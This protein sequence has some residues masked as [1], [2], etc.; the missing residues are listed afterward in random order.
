MASSCPD[1]Q[2]ARHATDVGGRICFRGCVF[3]RIVAVKFRGYA[4]FFVLCH[5]G[6]ADGS[7]T[8]YF[9]R[10]YVLLA[11]V[12]TSGVCMYFRL[13]VLP[14]YVHFRR[15]YTPGVCILPAYVYF[16]LMYVYL[17]LMYTS[18]VCILPAYVCTSGV[19]T[20]YTA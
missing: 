7:P 2:W 9:R 19:R 10:A 18:G 14:A 8:V 6:W 17:R 20:D 16:R 11:Y 12:C 3:G 5:D 4:A 13:C 1:W 15:M